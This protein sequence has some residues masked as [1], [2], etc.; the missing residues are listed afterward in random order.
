MGFRLPWQ[1]PPRTPRFISTAAM[2]TA[3]ALALAS[4]AAFNLLVQA[5][6]IEIYMKS[7]PEVRPCLTARMCVRRACELRL[8]TPPEERV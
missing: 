3:S 7:I 5:R 4:L 2:R 6:H 1:G 8:L